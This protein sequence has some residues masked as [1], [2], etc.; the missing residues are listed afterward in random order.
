M[1]NIAFVRIDKLFR[2]I[3]LF[4]VAIILTGCA[5]ENIASN[6]I[7]RDLRK[8]DL[9]SSGD[10]LLQA[11]LDGNLNDVEKLLQPGNDIKIQYNK[12]GLNAL[13]LAVLKGDLAVT[14]AILKN[15]TF[16]NNV[17]KTAPNMQGGAD[18]EV[19]ALCLAVGSNNNKDLVELLIQAGADLDKKCGDYGM[20]PLQLA[21]FWGK[22][23]PIAL[24]VNAGA[25][26]Y[27]LMGVGSDNISL[28]GVGWKENQIGAQ[29]ALL[30]ALVSY[31]K[32]N[33]IRNLESSLASEL[34]SEKVARDSQS[35][36]LVVNGRVQ[37]KIDRV[38][39]DSAWDVCG[40]TLAAG[41]S[42]E[43]NRRFF[44]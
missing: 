18:G 42:V 27:A 39:T 30:D 16:K 9:S 22:P 12:G 13:H 34:V 33:G 43:E 11:T 8:W 38:I 26:I 36:E 25:N 31:G 4:G 17:D 14:R 29:F 5:I 44:I 7:N 1:L 37:K 28:L 35:R 20:T 23:D 19:S 24:L 10:S 2:L 3:V 6:G 32:Q 21:M 15:I 41:A 40:P